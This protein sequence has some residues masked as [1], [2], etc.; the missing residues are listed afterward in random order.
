MNLW[1]LAPAAL[2]ALAAPALASAGEE[3][4]CENCPAHKAH[5]EH[6]AKAVPAAATAVAGAVKKG[7]RTIPVTVTSDGFTP[8]EVKAK[9]GETVKLVVTRKVQRT[10]ATEIVMKDFGVNQPLPLD[11]AVTVTVK[12][13]AP[14]TYRFACGMDMIAGNLVVE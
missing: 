2:L 4:G 8:A 12:P 9:T 1:K 7:V 3:G 5:A 14:G 11:Q 13:K 6:G 10:C